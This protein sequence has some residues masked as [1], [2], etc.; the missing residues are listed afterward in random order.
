MFYIKIKHPELSSWFFYLLIYFWL[1]CLCCCV[2]F[3]LAA[4]RGATLQLQRVGSSLGWVLLGRTGPRAHGLQ[5]LRHVR[6]VVVAREPRLWSIGSV[7]V[8]H[9]LSCSVGSSWIRDRTHFSCIG[10]WILYLWATKEAQVV[11]FWLFVRY[12]RF[13][14]DECKTTCI[15]KVMASVACFQLFQTKK[16][17]WNQYVKTLKTGGRA[18]MVYEHLLLYS[19]N[20]LLGLVNLSEQYIGNKYLEKM[21]KDPNERKGTLCR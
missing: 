9:G 6:T 15:W 17:K 13:L 14:E 20:Y 2:Y 18:W 19:W 1:C 11:L 7:A 16:I 12:S 4:V 10:R 21:K 3:P 5:E 8:A